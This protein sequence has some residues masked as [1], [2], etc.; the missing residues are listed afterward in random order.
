MRELLH[1]PFTLEPERYEFFEGGPVSRRD[2][3][4]V[5]GGGLVLLLLHDAPSA[6]AQQ[7]RRPGGFGRPM[8]QDIAAWLHIGA[9]NTV[10]VYTGKVE[11]GQN[12]RT[13]LAQA[14]AEELRAPI[15]HIRMVMADTAVVPFDMGTFGSGTTPR[16]AS[17]LRKM[18]AAA[19]EL[20]LDMAAK[21]AK[22]DRASLTVADG[23]V[24]ASGSQVEFTFGQLTGGKKLMKV[25]GG[26]VPTTPASEWKVAGTPVHKLNGAA[27][28]T[29]GHKYASD[30][31][32]E[33]M[34]HGKVVRPPAFGAKLVSADVSKAQAMPGVTVVHE[35]DFIA[36]AAP[37]EHE[38]SKAMAAIHTEWKTEPQPSDKELFEYLKQHP[39]EAGGGF[40]GRSNQEAGSIKE[41]LG[42]AAHKLEATYTVAYIA[43]VPLEPRAAVAEWQ[44]DKLTAWTGTQRPFGVRSDLARALKLPEKDVH[45]I[46]P[47]TGSGYGGKHSGEA[48]LEAARL[49]KA[50]GRPVKVVWT[51]EEE[52][53]WA[54][55]RPAGVMEV[56]SGVARDGRLTAWEF[57]NYNSGGS[58]IQTPYDVP[59]QHVQF[60][61]TES[62]LR[63]G[64]YRVLA[65]TANVFARESHMDELAHAVRM[66]PLAFRLKNLAGG[67]ETRERLRAV[68]E[69]AAKQ[70]GWK[71]KAEPGHGFGIGGG[72]EKGGYVATCA[73][74]SVDRPRGQVRVVR[75][76]TAFDCGAVVNPDGLKNQIEGA[77]VMGLGGALFEA[78]RFADGKIQNPRL[79]SYR[80]PRF[81]DLP[82]LDTVLI[83]RRDKPSAGAGEAPLMA[84][85][86]AVG[87][88]I[89][90]ACGVR[91]RSMP[92]V[93]NGLK[94]V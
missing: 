9:D 49:A 78:I 89:F 31:R 15:E 22:V 18:A 29:G 79:S 86:P 16:M 19:R 28:V 85:A 47:D 26:N 52:M 3:F 69:A 84:V 93:P 12:I 36:V 33:G 39:R 71:S 62:P 13:S 42:A 80:V 83:D 73:E 61:P 94:A 1:D 44:G 72:V 48:A 11:L 7:R 21:K 57:H 58:S 67:G 87:N 53:T 34:L 40:G 37:T 65:A 90:A 75:L 92:M 4:K 76:V 50:S 60:H 68:F 14:V 35:G 38:A 77:V 10:T 6:D 63:Q 54:Y 88:A 74:V 17:Q 5:V 81:R 20:L 59:N 46:V 8:P 32:R 56:R 2:F 41:G 27:I 82:H 24:R 45:V 64:S 43:H 55:F 70:F 66:D 23:T 51:R 30:V 91:L 25:V